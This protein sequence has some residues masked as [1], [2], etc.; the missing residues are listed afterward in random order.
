MAMPIDE[1]NGAIT[2][3]QSAFRE[4]H[5]SKTFEVSC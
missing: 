4:I 2:F 3:E 5:E 1:V